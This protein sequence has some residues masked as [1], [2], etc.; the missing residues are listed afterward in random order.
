MY[1]PAHFEETRPELL[2]DLISTHPL[3]LLVTQDPAGEMVANTIPFLLEA[4]PEGGPG[5]L[6]AHVARSNPLWRESRTDVDSLIVFQGPQTYIS[7][8]MYPSKA[9]TGKVVPTWNY[10][11][12]QGRG[13]LHAV[14]DA[15][16]LRAFVTRL[17][18][19]HEAARPV[20]WAVSDAPED[21]I[22]ATLRAIVGIEIKLGSL[23]GKWKVS[24]NRTQADRD[25]VVYGLRSLGGTEAEAMAKAIA[26]R[27]EPAR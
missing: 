15:D 16:W 25:G 10:I 14:E 2:H 21:F 27:N 6:R 8:S 4:D 5:I 1:I 20:P 19:R 23:R 9:A 3:G 24:Q 18:E 22:D 13:R 26:K 11:M 12:V 17:S 7:P